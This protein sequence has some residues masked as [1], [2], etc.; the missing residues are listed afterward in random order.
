MIR[1]NIKFVKS[2]DN[3]II[4]SPLPT[5]K[6]NIDFCIISHKKHMFIGVAPQS[7]VRYSL[8][9]RTN[10]MNMLDLRFITTTNATGYDCSY[11]WLR[12]QSELVASTLRPAAIMLLC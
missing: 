2:N 7:D 11:D 6:I 3:D 9:Q 1:T 10:I 4:F 5:E 12:P 8:V